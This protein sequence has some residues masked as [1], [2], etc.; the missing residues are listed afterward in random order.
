MNPLPNNQLTFTSGLLS[1]SLE[2]LGI[3]AAILFNRAPIAAILF[4]LVLMSVG[5]VLGQT[6]ISD[7]FN[8]NPGSDTLWTHYAPLQPPPW[9]EQVS[10][11]FPDDGEGGKGYRIFG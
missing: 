4:S 11:T 9:N 10:W 3:F 1:F 2:K 6:T 7:N 5:T 8:R